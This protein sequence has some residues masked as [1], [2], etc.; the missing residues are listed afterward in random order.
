MIPT[1]E[2]SIAGGEG[3]TQAPDEPRTTWEGEEVTAE[4]E[5]E[6][7]CDGVQRPEKAN[8]MTSQRLGNAKLYLLF[9]AICVAVF[10]MAL[11][12]SIV[13]TVSSICSFIRSIS[14]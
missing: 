5:K 2:R 7:S 14:S 8:T 12:G 11:N 6:D 1:T 9:V 4:E 3:T 13:S 10:L